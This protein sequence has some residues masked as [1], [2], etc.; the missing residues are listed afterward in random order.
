MITNYMVCD[1]I[2]VDVYKNGNLSSAKAI[3]IVEENN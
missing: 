2:I 1:S 3:L